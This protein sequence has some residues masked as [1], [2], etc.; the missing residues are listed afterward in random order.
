M[1]FRPNTKY[2]EFTN[3]FS[4]TKADTLAEHRP[5]DLKIDLDEGSELPLSQIYSHFQEE[6]KA[7]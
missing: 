2:Y 7:L 5:Y 3:V 1:V 4:K 6:Q